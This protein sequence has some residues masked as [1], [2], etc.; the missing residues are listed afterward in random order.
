[1]MIDMQ[2]RGQASCSPFVF[3]FFCRPSPNAMTYL[4]AHCTA[5][6]PTPVLGDLANCGACGVA[7]SNNHIAMPTCA[8]GACNGACDAGCADCNLMAAAGCETPIAVDVANCGGC[9]EVCSSNHITTP[10]CGGGGVCNGACD[11]G[12]ADCNNDELH[13]GCETAT[14]SDVNHCGG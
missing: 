8:G 6:A 4:D 12:Y 14:T 3:G 2:C 7:C 10:S 11:P 9:A 5:A 13:D 1:F